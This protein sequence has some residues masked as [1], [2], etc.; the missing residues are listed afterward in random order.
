MLPIFFF[1]LKFMAQTHAAMFL[2]VGLSICLI[3][4]ILAL[5]AI[6]HDDALKMHSRIW[7]DLLWILISSTLVNGIAGLNGEKSSNVTTNLPMQKF[8][9]FL[10]FY[11]LYEMHT[12]IFWD[13][14]NCVSTSLRSFV[15]FPNDFFGVCLVFVPMKPF[16]CF[17]RSFVWFHVQ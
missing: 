10:V 14:R 4:L 2:S 8:P 5:N 16:W 7:S 11:L 3:Q 1:C 6:I 17:C 9:I 12:D 13:M 15:R